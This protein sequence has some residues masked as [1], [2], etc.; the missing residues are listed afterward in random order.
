[1]Q[2][3]SDTYTVNEADGTVILTVTLIG[4]PTGDVKVDYATSDGTATA[5]TDYSEAMSSA[6]VMLTSRTKPSIAG[7]ASS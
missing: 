3:A 4:T 5:G 6:L 1:V 2:F 7:R